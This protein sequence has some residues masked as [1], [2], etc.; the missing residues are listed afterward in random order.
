MS[1]NSSVNDIGKNQLDNESGHHLIPLENKSTEK[2]SNVSDINK[3]MQER[4]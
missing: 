4:K 1:I 2:D 3:Q